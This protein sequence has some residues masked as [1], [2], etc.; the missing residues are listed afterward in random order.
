MAKLD[1]L[2]R[3]ERSHD[4][5]DELVQGKYG[6]YP[7]GEAYFEQLRLELVEAGFDRPLL[8]V[9]ADMATHHCS[10]TYLL[11]VR[12]DSNG[13]APPQLAAEIQRVYD[14][15]GVAGFFQIIEHEAS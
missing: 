4:D 14:E 9:H 11:Y 7:G 12:T 6:P 10:D 8:F 5:D 13:L 15:E 1:T 2:V 3:F